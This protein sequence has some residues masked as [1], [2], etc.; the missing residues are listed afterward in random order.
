MI[1]K[2]T[3]KE[4]TKI[5]EKRQLLGGEF[6]GPDLSPD[7]DL[8][9]ESNFLKSRGADKKN[10]EYGVIKRRE[11]VEKP[12]DNPLPGTAPTPQPPITPSPAES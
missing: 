7:F 8:D 6:G 9:T 1:L 11:V 2:G 3:S 12:A 10:E 5:N 4:C